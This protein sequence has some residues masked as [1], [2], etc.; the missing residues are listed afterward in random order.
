MAEREAM[1][2]GRAALPPHASR[3]E[4][5]L[6]VGKGRGNLAEP[7][8]GR[9]AGTSAASRDGAGAGGQDGCHPHGC[10][11]RHGGSREGRAAAGPGA[12][13]RQLRGRGLKRFAAAGEPPLI[14]YPSLGGNG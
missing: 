7:P 12:G 14:P 4:E 10:K 5:W 1:P 2:S 9:Q 11:I 8:A 3:G 13:V 6:R